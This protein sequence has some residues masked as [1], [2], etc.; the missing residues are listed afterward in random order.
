MTIPL[1]LFHD[2]LVSSGI[3]GRMEL[4]LQRADPSRLTFE[5]R[6]DVSLEIESL[7]RRTPFP[8]HVQT[9]LIELIDP[10]PRPFL[11]RT[12]AS[13]RGPEHAA[14]P[15]ETHAEVQDALRSAWS[16]T[17]RP[18]AFLLD[19]VPRTPPA[20][21]VTSLE[22]LTTEEEEDSGR[23]W[24]VLPDGELVELSTESL[25]ILL[26]RV[27]ALLAGARRPGPGAT[28]VALTR[29]VFV[30]YAAGSLSNNA[31][32]PED[33]FAFLTM[34]E[35]DDA[36]AC[37]LSDLVRRSF[38]LEDRLA[39]LLGPTRP[40]GADGRFA[41]TARR[42]QQLTGS[43]AAPGR[44]EG[45]TVRPGAFCIGA[46]P[47]GSAQRPGAVLICDR[48]TSRALAEIPDAAAAVER[49]GGRI[50]LGGFTARSAGIPCVSGVYD[51]ELIRDGERVLVDGDLGLVSLGSAIG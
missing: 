48:L 15:A 14:I 16:C 9:R 25:E 30:R 18:G 13:S 37:R 21:S 12:E 36:E 3:A 29:S 5:Q 4:L 39:E 11:V 49:L 38:A 1:R 31:F 23:R 17:W 27:E 41:T 47:G 28:E 19:S 51:A 35:S 24:D 20:V 33:P 44:A 22:E 42:A 46:R 10:L 50:G 6:C 26:G 43:T 40:E 34:P 8:D 2:Y 45:L 7:L 32:L